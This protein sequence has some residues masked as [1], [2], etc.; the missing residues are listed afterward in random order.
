MSG[1]LEG[2]SPLGDIC[3]RKPPLDV[4]YKHFGISDQLHSILTP[5]EMGG[6]DSG[7]RMDIEAVADHGEIAADY[8]IFIF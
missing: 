8:T 6:S 4:N 5:C 2:F 7:L 3:P 1:H